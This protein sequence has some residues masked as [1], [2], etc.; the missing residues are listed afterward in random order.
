MDEKTISS[1][2]VF[3]GRLLKIEVLD[4]ELENG[5]KT[6]R[7]IVRH[8]GA[9]A[10]IAQLPDGRFVLVRQFRKAIEKDL[11]EIVAG[12]LEPHE[13]P[14]DCA[15]REMKEETGF[16]CS[17]LKEL[18]VV[19]LTPGYSSERTHLFYATLLPEAGEAGPEEDENV[20][21]VCLSAGQIEDMISNGEIEDAKTLAAWLLYGRKTIDDK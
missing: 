21:V 7:E 19:Y 3:D 11:L 18:G 17:D 6:S 13:S 4:V 5:L 14:A 1:R 16:T 15:V 12:G 20:D 10:V 8:K 9:V 2:T